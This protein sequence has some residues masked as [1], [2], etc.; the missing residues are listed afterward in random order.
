MIA[1]NDELEAIY[2]HIPKNGGTYV[3]N[4][5]EHCYNFK[6]IL[7][8]DLGSESNSRDFASY[9]I[10]QNGGLVKYILKL[11]INNESLNGL[12]LE[13][14]NKYTKFTCIRN[15]YDRFVSSWNYLRYNKMKGKNIPFK[16]SLTNFFLNKHSINNYAYMH[17]FISQYDNITDSNGNICID[18]VCN[19]EN[20]NE[21]L[22]NMLFT[23]G[24]KEIKHG[25]LI[26]DN[27]ILNESK[28]KK[29][30]TEYYDN[31]LVSYINQYFS[32]DFKYFEF[33]QCDTIDELIEDSKK[34]IFSNEEIINKNNALLEELITN[35]NLSES[36]L[37]KNNIK[38]K[39]R[40]IRKTK[41]DKYKYIKHFKNFHTQCIINLFQS[42]AD[43]Q[44]KLNL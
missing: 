25:D 34:Y 12:T 7:F 24:I 37:N 33:K 20:F 40:F 4:V 22:I 14:W 26:K 32:N 29:P 17:G 8:N 10:K 44:N 35:N 21:E 19:F 1:I 31:L 42:F 27:I 23:L 41:F 13:K 2:V 16:M 5:L 18:Y 36:L 28:D 43:N 6:L 15:P 9:H 38:E 3:K 30:Y 11:L 39:N